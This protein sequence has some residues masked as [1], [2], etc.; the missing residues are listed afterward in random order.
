MPPFFENEDEL[1]KIT[2]VAQLGKA[3]IDMC[4]VLMMPSFLMPSRCRV[5]TYIFGKTIPNRDSN[6]TMPNRA[7]TL[8]K[9]ARVEL[10]L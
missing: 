2:C 8:T 3:S 1:Y 6:Q 9:R 5:E 7:E 10:R 4:H